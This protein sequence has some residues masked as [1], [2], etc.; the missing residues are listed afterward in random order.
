MIL[1]LM[2]IFMRCT[3]S[4]KKK[5]EG[6]IKEI[7]F[8]KEVS[9]LFSVLFLAIF[10]GPYSI[11]LDT[12]TVLLIANDHD[13]YD[14]LRHRF[15]HKLNQIDKV[16]IDTKF[17]FLEEHNFSSFIRRKDQELRNRIAHNNFGL[18]DN[19]EFLIDQKEV[20]IKKKCSDLLNFVNR[21]EKQFSESF[22]KTFKLTNIK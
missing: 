22:G 13:L 12:L 3:K 18:G 8:E 16:N 4:A 5:E 2:N 15:V 7:I 20:D 11:T 21:K 17:K 6:F 10:E 19:G 14:P 1:V 9:T